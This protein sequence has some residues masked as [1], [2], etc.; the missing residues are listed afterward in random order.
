MK[1]RFLLVLTLGLFALSSPAHALTGSV[2]LDGAAPAPETISADAD[3][4]CKA[5]HPDGITNDQVIVGANGELKNVFVYVKE[6]VTGKFE[7]PKESVVF[8]QKGCQYSPKVFGIQTG[9]T[10]EIVNSDSTLH[11]VHALPKNSKEFNLG[12]PVQN[13]KLKK[14]FDKP[15]VM[16]KIKCEVHPWMGAWAGVLDHPFFAVSGD[17]GKFDIKNLPPGQYVIEAWHEKY[18]TQTQNVT[19][20]DQPQDITFT[21]KAA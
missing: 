16:V 8:D 15:E 10:L 17:D 12:M 11:N 5:V 6:G 9:Q 19:V 7:A 4:T 3:P 21:F 1:T 14:K 18:G 2:K 20:T 13:M